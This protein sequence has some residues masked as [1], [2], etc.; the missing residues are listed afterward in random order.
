MAH[1]ELFSFNE[2]YNLITDMKLSYTK[3]DTLEIMHELGLE[4]E[5]T[6]KIDNL[7]Q[8]S[9][10]RRRNS[11]FAEFYDH[12]MN[13]FV[14]PS[15]RIVHIL[16]VV[17]DKLLSYKE[18]KLAYD[19]EWVLKRINNDDIYNLNI[20]SMNISKD[21]ESGDIQS[22][23]KILSEYSSDDF[24]KN[25]KEDIKTAKKLSFERLKESSEKENS[26]SFRKSV[27]LKDIGVSSF[28]LSPDM[29]NTKHFCS[30]LHP[31][32]S[33]I[34]KT[35]F[36][37][38]SHEQMD[39]LEIDS[40]Y[41]NV[42]EYAKEFGREN[43]LLNISD[44]IFNK[45]NL[46]CIVSPEKFSRF[47]DMIRVGYN[48][49]LPYHNDMHAADVVQTCY[50]MSL[51]LDM[52]EDMDLSLIDLV[53]FFVAA[54]VHDY[55]H[56]GLNNTYHINKRSKVATKYNDVS[57]LE[58][59]HISSAFK[60]I[61]HPSCNIFSDLRVEEYR[62]IRKRIIECVLATDMAK[63]TK[64]QT[65]IK[66]KLE[67]FKGEDNTNNLYNLIHNQCEDSKF[68]RQ[69]EVLN[70][71]I[72]CADISNP[73]KHFSVCKI[74]TE[75]V[76]E[77]FFNQGDLERSEKLPVSFLC[78]RSSTNIPKSQINFINNIATPCFKIMNQLSGKTY[79][80]LKN[81]K[82]NVEEWKKLEK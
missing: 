49:L 66:I 27:M 7:V 14:T 72:H 42:F 58:N 53:G 65:T 71:L 39:I 38:E 2:F 4:K 57:V 44:Y 64:S 10:D 32:R 45:H 54:I 9:K 11:R 63:H 41:F 6:I 12:V 29:I 20:N 75:K 16:G 36:E 59:Y 22:T 69:Q 33:P 80:F 77:E 24:N 21:N 50:H 23:M 47:I 55:K 61:S 25:K 48:P 68:D 37:N 13:L 3:N 1:H 34:N 18:D 31:I 81:L 67:Q 26:F 82:R 79:I 19:L 56:P 43:T 70:F 62:V 78:D 17:K 76:M 28:M 30:I 46:F 74:W 5:D 51:L 52:K 8:L 73:A 60:V 40:F 35:I 15:E